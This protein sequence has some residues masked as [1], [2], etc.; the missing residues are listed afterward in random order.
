MTS[1]ATPACD[2]SLR[3]LCGRVLVKENGDAWAGDAAK[4]RSTQLQK[5]RTYLETDELQP[6]YEH[7]LCAAS[8]QAYCDDGETAASDGSIASMADTAMRL[9]RSLDPG[10]AEFSRLEELKIQ[11]E[12]RAHLRSAAANAACPKYS[13]FTGAKTV[14]AWTEAMP[15]DATLTTVSE[16]TWMLLQIAVVPSRQRMLQGLRYCDAAAFDPKVSHTA[17]VDGEPPA[18]L[19]CES[20]V[21]KTLVLGLHPSVGP[22]SK[23]GFYATVNLDAPILPEAA[24]LLPLVRGGL[25][26]LCQ[27]LND[28]ARVFRRETG[29]RYGT[30]FGRN[31]LGELF[32]ATF[33][34][35]CGVF[36]KAVEQ[37]AVELY[38]DGDL[39]LDQCAEVH[40]RCQHKGE[41]AMRKYV[42]RL[43]NMETD[44]SSTTHT[45][46]ASGTESSDLD[47]SSD[48]APPPPLARTGPTTAVGGVPIDTQ[49]GSDSPPRTHD[50]ATQTESDDK[51]EPA[52]TEESFATACIKLWK[53]ARTDED[54]GLLEMALHAAKRAR[55]C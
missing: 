29:H 15:A 55:G 44:V 7:V 10:N 3:V 38:R 21:P 42:L 49:C 5:L 13:V 19:V 41:T 52:Q 39:T 23:N 25:T 26:Q 32:T 14:P 16:C 54:V 35:S 8:I 1:L 40:R 36:R 24:H 2:D 47:Q 51:I 43:Q 22:H 46:G 37:R 30:G 18:T 33:E 12:H 28:G 53:R 31:H 45:D 11:A 27:G 17:R 34:H 9:L 50:T 20:H 4:L 48:E 6:T